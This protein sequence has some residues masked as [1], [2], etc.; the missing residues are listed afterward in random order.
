MFTMEDINETT[1]SVYF[2]LSTIWVCIN[3]NKW[4]PKRKQGNWFNIALLGGGGILLPFWKLILKVRVEM[5]EQFTAK[6]FNTLVSI[7]ID[8][9]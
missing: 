1:Y 6:L 7:K 8:I 5:D 9:F 4:I 2:K 3:L